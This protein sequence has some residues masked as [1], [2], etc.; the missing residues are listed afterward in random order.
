M[1]RASRRR[2]DSAETLINCTVFL[3]NQ[4]A[5]V[6]LREIVEEGCQ[7]YGLFHATREPL[8]T[9]R[10]KGLRANAYDSH[11][12]H[13]IVDRLTARLQP[14]LAELRERPR[15]VSNDY[16]PLGMSLT[17]Q[18]ALAP[19]HYSAVVLTLE[20]SDAK[21]LVDAVSEPERK[22]RALVQLAR[23]RT[24]DVLEAMRLAY[25]PQTW[26]ALEAL[27]K[28]PDGPYVLLRMKTV[29]EDGFFSL[30]PSPLRPVQGMLRDYA[31]S[32]LR[33]QAR[34]VL[35]NGIIPFDCLEVVS[36]VEA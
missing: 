18:F 14:E 28:K 15:P 21:G 6:A 29:P 23:E 8:E 30:L 36:G 3:I 11:L 25:S 26:S 2:G 16:F 17:E 1:A 20:V 7:P 35:F 13:D 22:A 4:D 33:P 34:A 24:P 19:I 31:E 9:L 10:Q 5:M 27:Q 32:E 12:V